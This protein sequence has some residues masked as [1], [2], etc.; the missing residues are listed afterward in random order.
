MSGFSRRLPAFLRRLLPRQHFEAPLITKNIFHLHF[1]CTGNICRSPFAAHLAQ[2]RAADRG[3]EG[4]VTS[5]SGTQAVTQ[6]S[7][8]QAALDVARTQFGVHMN[9]HRGAQISPE[10]LHQVDAV[11]VMTVE[12]SRY[13]QVFLVDHKLDSIPI[14]N[15]AEQDPD[16]PRRNGVP[17]PYG[18]P[19]WAYRSSYG[20]IEKCVEGLLDRIVWPPPEKTSG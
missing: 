20:Y 3:W 19:E 18:H 14:L 10:L 9:A 7:C 1:V 15:L 2:R 11:V 6:G 5:S 12:H 17:D 16:P 8:P 4:F 13:V